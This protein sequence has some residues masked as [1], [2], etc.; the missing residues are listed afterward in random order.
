MGKGK[1]SKLFD[2]ESGNE[3]SSPEKEYDQTI[4]KSKRMLLG[5]DEKTFRLKVTAEF[6]RIIIFTSLEFFKRSFELEKEFKDSMIVSA[7]TVSISP[8]LFSSFAGF[9]N[10]KSEKEPPMVSSDP[11]KNPGL[12]DDKINRG[13]NQKEKSSAFKSYM[14]GA[15]KKSDA[16]WNSGQSDP[17]NYS[18]GLGIR[19]YDF[20]LDY[21][22]I[23]GVGGGHLDCVKENLG[24]YDFLMVKPTRDEGDSVSLSSD[25]SGSDDRPEMVTIKLKP[26]IILSP[27]DA[28]NEESPKKRGGS[29]KKTG[30]KGSRSPRMSMAVPALNLGNSPL[31]RDSENLSGSPIKSRRSMMS[32]RKSARGSPQKEVPSVGLGKIDGRTEGKFS[33][34]GFDGWGEGGFGP[35]MRIPGDQG[36][37]DSQKN[38]S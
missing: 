23:I 19:I 3:D 22:A 10:N 5:P 28:I 38:L 4:I 17:G 31:E 12:S 2:S 29:P 24:D 21:S 27:I 6:M 15:I 25:S 13:S 26:P 30:I 7:P 9:T 36:R 18:V 14:S 32:P 37:G 33:K 34:K 35:H 8:G 11:S 16:L 1:G 20:G